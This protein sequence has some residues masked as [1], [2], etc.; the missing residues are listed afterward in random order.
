MPIDLR[1]D[2][3][4]RPAVVR[5]AAQDP[6]RFGF[7]TVFTRGGLP[8]ADTVHSA[9]QLPGPAATVRVPVVAGATGLGFAESSVPI[10]GTVPVANWATRADVSVTLTHTPCPL[11]TPLAS[12]P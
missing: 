10:P 8:C 3:D 4:E 12:C 7:N 1:P 9:L 6:I 5:V 2:A 11:A